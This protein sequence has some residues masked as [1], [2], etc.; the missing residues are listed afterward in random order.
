MKKTEFAEKLNIIRNMAERSLPPVEF[1]NFIIGRGWVKKDV[2]ELMAEY[3]DILEKSRSFGRENEPH[4]VTLQFPYMSNHASLWQ[5]FERISGGTYYRN[6]FYGVVTIDFTLWEDEIDYKAMTILR[7]YIMEN[8][9]NVKFILTE[10]PSEL[11][12]RMRSWD[13]YNAAIIEK[14]KAE[15]GTIGFFVQG[16]SRTL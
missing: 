11:I 7:E 5:L 9:E 8:E 16:E 3:L 6:R 2:E 13:D 10:V 14:R 12:K 4:C 1:P 15:E